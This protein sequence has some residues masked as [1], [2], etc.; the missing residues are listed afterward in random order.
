MTD[1]KDLSYLH[2]GFALQR[3]SSALQLSYRALLQIRTTIAP[4]ESLKAVLLDHW[5]T[6]ENLIDSHAVGAKLLDGHNLDLATV[7]MVAR[8]AFKLSLFQCSF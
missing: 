1:A 4:F 6:F 5:Q 2:D 8:Y 7:L 3:S